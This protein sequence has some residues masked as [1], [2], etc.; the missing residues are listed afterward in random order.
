MKKLD[1]FNS[2]PFVIFGT[3][4]SG[5]RVVAKILVG[6]NCFIGSNLNKPL[7]N[8]DF[9]FLLAGRVDWMEKNFPF[10]NQEAEKFLLLFKK[11]YFQQWISFYDFYLLAKIGMEFFSGNSRRSFARRPLSDRIQKGLR[12]SKSIFFPRPSQFRYYSAWGFKSPEAIYFLNP[13]I[14]LFKGIKLIHM[15]R[16]GRDMAF[17]KQ[18][19]PLQYLSLFNVEEDDPVLKSFKNWL[20]VNSWAQKFCRRNLSTNQYLKINYEELC[21]HPSSTVCRLIEFLELKPSNL[22]YLQTIPQKNPSI[23]RWKR[24]PDYQDKFRNSDL[25]FLGY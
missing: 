9:G 21:N 8:Q 12:M 16:D 23:G 11:I 13:L 17:S 4:G 1:L 22:E 10:E 5:T 6:A 2:E 18:D 3:G 24:Y 15:I 14:K 20:Q 25:K 19:T 7:D